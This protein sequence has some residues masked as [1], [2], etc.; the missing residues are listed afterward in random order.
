MSHNRS[1][2]KRLN[3]RLLVQAG[4]GLDLLHWANMSNISNK[5]QVYK[6]ILYFFL[7]GKNSSLQENSKHFVWEYIKE[8]E[9][10][11]TEHGTN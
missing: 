3:P 1:I 7:K 6:R 2:Y 5:T 9:K 4:L 8:W 11:H 10:K